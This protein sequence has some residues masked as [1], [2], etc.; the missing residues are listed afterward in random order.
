M[1][2]Y[3]NFNYQSSIS[4]LTV[5]KVIDGDTFV[6]AKGQVI[7]LIC[8]D[9]P[10]QG[11]KGSEDA[12]AFLESLILNKE[13]ILEKDVSNTDKYD[14]LLRYVYVNGVFVNKEIINHGYGTIFRVEPDVKRCEEISDK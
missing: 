14:R 1:Y 12:K 6:L 8:I 2:N 10:E 9:A 5:I 13:V 11:T 7:R 3:D 4:E